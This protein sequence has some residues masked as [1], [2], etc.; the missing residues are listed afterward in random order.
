MPFELRLIH[1]QVCMRL[2]MTAYIYKCM[3]SCPNKSPT[4]ALHQCWTVVR[5]LSRFQWL[6][7]PCL[8][9]FR[10]Q[11]YKQKPRRASTRVGFF[12][13][14]YTILLFL[15]NQ[16]KFVTYSTFFTPKFVTYSKNFMHDFVTYSIFYWLKTTTY[17]VFGKFMAHWWGFVFRSF[18][19]F[20]PNLSK[21]SLS[22]HP[23]L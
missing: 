22:L 12:I 19:P 4:R 10:L 21:K 23:Y 20:F 13:L 6:E 8:F 15:K 9:K 1:T 7:R 2:P 14:I 18:W 3:C 11:R 5:V 17:S 16:Y